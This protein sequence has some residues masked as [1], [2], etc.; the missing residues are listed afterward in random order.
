MGWLDVKCHRMRASPSFSQAGIVAFTRIVSLLFPPPWV[1][2]SW[3]LCFCFLFFFF[4]EDFLGVRIVKVSFPM[5]V[6][7]Y[8]LSDSMDSHSALHCKQKG[9][10]QV[11]EKVKFS[12]RA[13][14]PECPGPCL[15]LP[16]GREEAIPD[17][18]KSRDRFQCSWYL[19][20]DW[21]ESHKSLPFMTG[22]HLPME[23]S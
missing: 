10:F 3:F 17:M 12:N 18:C 6:G 16:W 19:Y 20:K 11:T 4:E 8:K 1:T 7:I 21:I 15:S 22:K 5:L 2:R 9:D 23:V 13:E 14:D